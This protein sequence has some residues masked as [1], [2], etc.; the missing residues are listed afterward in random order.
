MK[1]LVITLGDPAGI[2]PEIVLRALQE[3]RD[4]PVILCGS[5]R[6]TERTAARLGIPTLRWKVRRDTEASGGDFVDVGNDIGDVA[7]GEPGVESGRVALASITAGIA[8][9]QAGRGSALVTAPV[10][11]EAI[12]RSGQPFTGHTELL[13]EAAGLERYGAD[14]A[15]YFE[16]PELRVAL[17]TVHVPLARAVASI[18]APAITDLARLLNRTLPRFLRTTP[19]ILVAAVNPHGGES[20]MFGGEEAAIREGVAAAAEQ[21][22]QISGPHPADTLFL[23]AMQ[24][25][26]SVV[27]AMY[28]DQGL[29]P[30]KTIAFDRSVNI[31]LGLPWLRVSVDHGTA[32]D[33]AGRGVADIR[34]M[35]YAIDR[36][37]EHGGRES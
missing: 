37:W 6:E 27:I 1:P 5:W 15:M 7:P 35:G 21:G 22:I 25:P 19:R 36:A 11:K 30:I 2:G 17:L 23:S 10:S 32:F 31:T 13:A 14:Y 12:S 34:P 4:I 3:R 28:H 18:S 20:G 26:A 24:D 33:I 29:I 9:M 16:S 8:L